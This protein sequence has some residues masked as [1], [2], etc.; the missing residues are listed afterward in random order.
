MIVI[1]GPPLGVLLHVAPYMSVH[2]SVPCLCHLLNM[3]KTEV[4]FNWWWPT[5]A[6]QPRVLKGC[7]RLVH[8][9]GQH[10]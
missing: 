7:Y 2:L 9:S 4:P 3:L 10:T 6:V 8:Q 5:T 1:S